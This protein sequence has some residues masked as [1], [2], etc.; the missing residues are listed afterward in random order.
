MEIAVKIN[1]GDDTGAAISAGAFV[2]GIA[3]ENVIKGKL[4][5]ELIDKVERALLE[6]GS[7]VTIK[8]L[9]LGIEALTK[10][11][12]PT[13]PDNVILERGD[14]NKKHMIMV[15]GM[16]LSFLGMLM[17]LHSIVR[18]KKEGEIEDDAISDELFGWTALISCFVIFGIFFYYKFF[19]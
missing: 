6:A 15:I 1:K 10:P 14:F 2:V 17:G 9:K 7:K 16:I 8:D 11:L 13:K 18:K 12:S 5:A 4:R 3:A 19:R